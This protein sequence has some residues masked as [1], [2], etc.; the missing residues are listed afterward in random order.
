MSADFGLRVSSSSS[1]AELG[2]ELG[3]EL[4]AVED[5]ETRTRVAIL[6]AARA[7]KSAT[8]AARA[9]KSAWVVQSALDG[10]NGCGDEGSVDG[11]LVAEPLGRIEISISK[12]WLAWQ[13]AR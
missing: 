6:C 3:G 12:Q 10:A 2:G 9:R 13:M 7:R 4:G 5:A 1:P 11:D 8:W